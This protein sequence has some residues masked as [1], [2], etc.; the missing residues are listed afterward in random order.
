MSGVTV[1]VQRVEAMP[2]ASV[3][4]RV[5]RANFQD[6]TGAS[7]VWSIIRE[8][9]LS[10]LDQA[11][12]V[13]HDDPDLMLINQPG[14][15]DVDVGVRLREPFEN[16][17]ILT[18]VMTPGGLTAHARHQGSYAMLPVIHTDIRAWCVDQGR[19]I[20]GLCWELYTVWNED[21]ELRITDVYYQ[22][23]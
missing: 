2:V 12:V 17:T 8:H 15:L 21:P 7:P 6:V 13:Y 10:S 1:S 11:V 4:R 18:C 3:Q 14:G 19:K 23:R 22:L 20:T 9:K 5:T 16:D